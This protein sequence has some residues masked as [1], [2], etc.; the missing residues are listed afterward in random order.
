LEGPIEACGDL[1]PEEI[2]FSIW[3][4]WTIQIQRTLSG[5]P[6][7]GRIAPA[8][9]EHAPFVKSYLKQF[10]LFVLKP[11]EDAQTRRLLKADYYLEDVSRRLP[12]YCLDQDPEELGIIRGWRGGRQ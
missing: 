4:R 1:K 8:R 6:I 2:C 11:I 10:R 5:L 7:T 3:F 12:M 9:I